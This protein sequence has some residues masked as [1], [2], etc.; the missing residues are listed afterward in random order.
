MMGA[1]MSDES[2]AAINVNSKEFIESASTVESSSETQF[3][4]QASKRESFDEQTE[5]QNHSR[6]LVRPTLSKFS[7]KCAHLD[8]QLSASAVSQ[9]KFAP[10]GLETAEL[11]IMVTPGDMLQARNH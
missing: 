1:S 10:S 9:P 2:E 3:N 4:L 11:E 6:R 5:L 7:A 8:I